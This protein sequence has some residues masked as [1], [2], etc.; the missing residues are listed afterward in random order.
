M[1]S[2]TID[3]DK[4]LSSVEEEKNTAIK[5]SDKMYDGMIEKSDSFFQAQSDAVK[6]YGE[7]QKKLQQDATDFTIEKIEQEKAQAG[8]DFKKEASAAYVDW[9]KQK[10]DY[11]SNAEKM[12]SSGLASSGYSETSKVAMY[13]QYQSRVAAAKESYDRAVLSYNNAIKEAT[14]QNNSALAEV[15]YNTLL[16]S[17]QLSLQGFQYKNDLLVQKASSKRAID[18]T[19]YGRYRDTVEQINHEKSVAEQIRQF[20]ASLA[21]ERRQFN[22]NLA[23]QKKKSNVSGSGSSGGGTGD[24]Y[25]LTPISTPKTAEQM[26]RIKQSVGMSRSADG[27][28]N[29]I[30]KLFNDGT[31]TEAEANELLENFGLKG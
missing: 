3:D 25:T 21:E 24:G 16:Q 27:R 6:Q 14:L 5:E 23:F 10:D 9:Q 26:N 15:A 28:L 4:R 17:L 18:D 29:A 12:A 13:N 20:N 8:K 1:A 22:E 19:Y 31:I 30:E 7:T 2:K 11:G